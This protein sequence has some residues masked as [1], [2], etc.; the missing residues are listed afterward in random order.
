[1]TALDE[2]AFSLGIRDEVPNQILAKKLASS[3]DS[4]GIR[5]I[6]EHL[7]DKNTNIQNDCIKV[8]YEVGEN[9]PDLIEGYTEDFVK[10]LKS[11]NNRMV[12]GAMTAIATIARGNPSRLS[13]YIQDIINSTHSGSVI[14]VDNGIK[15]LAYIATASDENH[16]DVFP[17]LLDHLKS[18]RPKE[19]PQHAES[20]WPAVTTRNKDDF[21]KVLM[22]RLDDLTPTGISRVRK[23]IK[24]T[25]ARL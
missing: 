22:N 11:K 12:W 20:T 18:C 19:V 2:I 14:T 16:R 5:E 10:L 4:E 25:Q 23:V 15:A 3:S 1:M 21:I 8:L 6:A 24:Q 7:W 13:P 9:R 17:F